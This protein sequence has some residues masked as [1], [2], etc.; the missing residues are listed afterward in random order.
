MM[1]MDNSVLNRRGE[2]HQQV[3]KQA[4]NWLLRLRN[5]ATNSRL[6]QQC[7]SLAGGTP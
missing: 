6:R 5:N 1:P 4:I 7:D 2:P 3:V